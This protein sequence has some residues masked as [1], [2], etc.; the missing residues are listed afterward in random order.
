MRKFI[1]LCLIYSLSTVNLQ[2]LTIAEKKAG[3]TPGTSDLSPDLE[4][5]LTKINEKQAELQKKLH[6]THDQVLILY[7][8]NAPDSEYE[9]LLEQIHQL[10]V[11][12]ETLQTDWRE[13][14]ATSAHH[15]DGYALWHQPQ[16]SAM[17]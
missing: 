9:P 1:L 4:K 5:L 11:E 7:H 6:E 15:E 17:I 16:T 2:A 12:I 10:Q 14:A 8:K 3:I 13:T